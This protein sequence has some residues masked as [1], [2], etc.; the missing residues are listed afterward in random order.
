M[1]MM[2]MMIH[3]THMICMCCWKWSQHAWVKR[4]GSSHNLSVLSLY[5]TGW[6]VIATCNYL[7]HIDTNNC[8][9]QQT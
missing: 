3:V 1:M 7:I 5:I 8:R 9:R 4:V 6:V 2:M